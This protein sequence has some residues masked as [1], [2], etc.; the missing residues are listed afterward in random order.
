MAG[1]EDENNFMLERG[2]GYYVRVSA[3]TKWNRSA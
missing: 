2:W 3:E 1:P